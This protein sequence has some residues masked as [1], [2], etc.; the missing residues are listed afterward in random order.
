MRLAYD[1]TG[2]GSAPPLVLIHGIGSRRGVWKPVV[3]LLAA[4]RDVL[5]VDLPGF[6]DSPLLP[7]GEKPTVQAL[8]R[9]VCDW[10]TELGLERPHVGGNSLGGGIALELARMGAVASATA[11]SPIGFWNDVEA[12][13]GRVMLRV[14]HLSATGRIGSLT[15]RV[16]RSPAGRQATIGLMYG[17][18]RKRDA[19]EVVEDLD[20]LARAP[21][22]EATLPI[23]REYAFGH[24]EELRVPVTIGWGTRDR[25]L[26]PRQAQRAR[27]A[28]PRARHVPLPGCGHIPMSDDPEGVAALLLAGSG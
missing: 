15:R 7:G 26:I 16:V 27:A 28:L 17:R 23:S 13:Y 25:L 11:L 12:R 2:T 10:W 19:D 1:R 21:G 24:G 8:A 20:Q 3:P 9:A 6:G 4:E 22:W 5:C 14:T 18:P